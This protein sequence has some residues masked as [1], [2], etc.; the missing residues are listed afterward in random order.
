MATWRTKACL[1]F[2]FE[3]A[4]YSYRRG[5]VELF[6]DLVEMA[7]RAANANDTVAMKQIAEYVSWAAAQKSPELDSAVDLAF[8]LPLFQDAELLATLRPY[9]SESL[10][11]GK[12]QVLMEASA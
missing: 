7:R 10:V 9:F 6:R 12:W 4:R 1:E 5:K 8:L 11:L 3:P 2:G